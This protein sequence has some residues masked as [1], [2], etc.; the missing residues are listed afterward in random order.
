MSLGVKWHGLS[1]D[2]TFRQL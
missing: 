2:K 1:S